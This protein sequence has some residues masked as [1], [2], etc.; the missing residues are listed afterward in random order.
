[1]RHFR[2][3]QAALR[4]MPLER[5]PIRWLKFVLAGSLIG[6]AIETTAALA[7]FYRFDPAWA[8]FGVAL[9]GFGVVLGTLAHWSRA[10]GDLFQ[11]ALGTAVVGAAELLNEL[12]LSGG[13]VRWEFAPGFPLGITAGWLRV[14]VLATAGGFVVLLANALAREAYKARFGIR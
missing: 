3:E 4:T 8:S 14:A 13:L 12:G 10:R 11:F 5:G 6:A 9:G 7:H 1:V 2:A